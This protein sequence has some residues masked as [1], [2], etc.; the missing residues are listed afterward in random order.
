MSLIDLISEPLSLGWPNAAF[1]AAGVVAC[2]LLVHAVGAAVLSRLVREHLLSASI[3]HEARRPMM[4]VLPLLAL[5][6]LWHVSDD[7][8]RGIATIRHVNVLL[9]IAALTWLALRLV[10]GVAAGV[11]ELHPSG[12]DDNL[13]A[14]SIRTQSRV[15]AR[16]FNA[17]FVVIGLALMIMT[18][19]G[20]SRVGASLLA[21]AGVAGL[22]AGLAARPAISNL[23]A[24]LQI[25]ITQPIRID[26]V[27]IV[28]GEWGRVEEITGAYVV[29]RIWDERRMVIPLQWFI[30]NPFQNWTRHSA[31]LTGTVFLWVD[32]GTPIEPLRRE[33][34][35]LCAA[36][37]EWDGRTC[38]L[39]VTDA[40]ERALQLRVQV[41]AA[42]ADRVWVLRCAVREGL[43]DFMQ[44]ECPQ[45]L[46]RQRAELLAAAP[47]EIR[48]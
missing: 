33:A 24:G 25:A 35:R 44:R 46:P 48:R 29:L 20:A 34:A 30:E 43:V 19:P 26:D 27:L 16:I 6:L 3:E 42:N 21:S 15:L 14:R 18:F 22:L 8:L 5:Q 2:A 13:Q 39:E 12:G 47:L 1:A 9:L 10:R 28:Q 45:H 36:T 4:V 11:A 32:Y 23:I 17:I 40:T 38:I 7:R 41:T 37:P 31:Q